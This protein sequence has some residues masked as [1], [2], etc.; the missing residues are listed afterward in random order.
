MVLF[1]PEDR[2]RDKRQKA[3]RAIGFAMSNRWTE[4][5]ELN[6]ELIA[7]YPNEVDSHNRLGKALMEL[8]RYSEARDAYA[9]SLRIDPLNSIAQKN[10]ARLTK[11]V[12]EEAAASE[13]APTPVDPSLFIE[14][15]GKTV[16]TMVADVAAADIL[17]RL[18][19]GDSVT[20]EPHRS[21]VRALGPGGERL[22]KLEP[23]LGQ[24]VI[25]LINQGNQY[26]AAVTAVDEQSLRIIIREVHRDPSMGDRPS[27][28]TAATAESFRAYT[29]DTVIR[30]D[31]EEE[32]D[33][34]DETFEDTDGEREGM[35]EAGM[36]VEG[37]V[38]E[39][40]LSDDA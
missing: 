25:N 10:V 32:D 31:V 35:R 38:D 17:A 8:G 34:D 40:D 36:E 19:A 3:E 13:P 28:P 5:V 4:A 1:Q 30:Y 24:R 6:R 16:V 2:L 27:F 33:E 15:T 7:D 9:E 11:L 14:E 21:M 23:K 26:S 20:L 18:T 12:E 22:G 37:G 39:P 29:R